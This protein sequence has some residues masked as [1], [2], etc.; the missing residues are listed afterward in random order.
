[1]TLTVV[2]SLVAQLVT[3]GK[4]HLFD[5]SNCHIVEVMGP[6]LNHM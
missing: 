5:S 3:H 6:E 2:E 4:P 1:M